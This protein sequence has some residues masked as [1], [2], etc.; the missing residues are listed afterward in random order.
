MAEDVT[1]GRGERVHEVDVL[2][3]GYGAAGAAAAL[4]AHDA[5]ARV[6]VVEKCV[7]PGGNSLVSSANTVYPQRPEDVE[8][9]CRLDLGIPLPDV[10][11]L[12][13]STG[14]R[15][16]RRPHRRQL[17]VLPGQSSSPRRSPISVPT[18][19]AEASR[20]P[21]TTARGSPRPGTAVPIHQALLP[22]P[23]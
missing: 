7:Q 11:Q 21:T 20:S 23:E 19:R 17:T 3:V 16:D 14:I 15:P 9:F 1:R 10:D 5:G 2:V 18:R 8:R 22:A 12:R 4:A 13:R 6:L